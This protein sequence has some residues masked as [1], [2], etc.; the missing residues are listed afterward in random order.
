VSS[1]VV[2]SI[3]LD[4]V[5]T[6]YGRA[7][8]ALGGT[9]VYFSIAASLFSD[10][11]VV[12]VVGRDFP[13]DHIDLLEARGCDLDGLQRRE[14]RTFRWVGSYDQNMNVAHTLDTQLNVFEAFRPELPLSYRRARTLFL[15]NIDPELQLDVLE[16]TSAPL[17]TALDT[18]NFWIDRKRDALEEVI[19]RVDVVLVNEDEARQFSGVYHIGEAARRIRELGPHTVVIKRGE[20]GSVMFT[21]DCYFAL[22]AFPSEDV[23]DTTGAGDSFAGGFLGYLDTVDSISSRELKRA[24]AFGTV[25]ASFAVENFSISGVHAADL[26]QIHRRYEALRDL[27]S[28]EP[29]TTLQR[30]VV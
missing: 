30:A 3:A 28:F 5:E 27:T 14:G 26:E 23:R 18:M 7:E 21:D 17:I 10:V 8:E 2:G 24:L 25:M 1:L 19:R 20:Y 11:K 9:A 15:G 22:P 4:T 6:P 29:I 16:Q 12:G 13:Q